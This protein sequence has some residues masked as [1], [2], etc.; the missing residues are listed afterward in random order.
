MYQKMVCT[1]WTRFLCHFQNGASHFGT[2]KTG[3]V[4]KQFMIFYQF[5]VGLTKMALL[6]IYML[7]PIK[8]GSHFFHK[9]SNYLLK[10]FLELT[11]RVKVPKIAKNCQI[12]AIFQSL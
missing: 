7:P 5:F 6:T 4:I 11:S 12:L 2:P 1:I 10:M 3:E 8:T 9:D